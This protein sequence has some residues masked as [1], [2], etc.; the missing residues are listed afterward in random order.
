MNGKGFYIALAVCLVAIG[1]A[2]YIAA[3]SSFGLLGED[4]NAISNY[5]PNQSATE[6]AAQA[7]TAVSGVPASSPAASSKSAASSEAEAEPSV[8]ILPVQGE[9]IQQYSGDT[10]IYNQTMDDWRVHN[11]VDIAASANTP[12]KACADGVV[13]EITTDDLMGQEIIIS[14]GNGL[15]SIYANL[16]S[17]VKVKKGQNVQAGDVIGTVGNTAQAEIAL[18][19]H[20]HFAV[21][22]DGKYVEPL[23]AIGKE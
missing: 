5:T 3:T 14:H 15:K 16:S 11:G 23:G 17:D 1:S 6:S 13:H 22:K 19:S 21:T 12:V 10:L 8:F 20:L 4:N 18:A 7:G 2:A 9:I